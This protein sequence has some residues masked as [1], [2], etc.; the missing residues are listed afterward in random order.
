MAHHVHQGTLAQLFHVHQRMLA[1]LL[2]SPVWRPS[3]SRQPLASPS[4]APVLSSLHMPSV[5]S[6]L[7]ITCFLT[8]HA[9]LAVRMTS[10]LSN[11]SWASRL[12]PIPD[13][14]TEPCLCSG[15][16]VCGCVCVGWVWVC[17]WVCL[18]VCVCK[19]Q[20]PHSIHVELRKTCLSHVVTTPSLALVGIAYQIRHSSVHPI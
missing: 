9:T 18:C 6:L 4:L 10:Y 7:S 12:G 19:S 2:L 1:Q 3:R 14:C 8:L 16:L 15:R 20:G 17:V 13:H 11:L 5:S